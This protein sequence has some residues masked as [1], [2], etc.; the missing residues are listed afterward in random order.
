MP[1]EDYIRGVVVEVSQALRP[2]TD[3]AGSSAGVVDLMAELGWSVDADAADTLITAFNNVVTA[4]TTL[5]DDVNADADLS[6]LVGDVGAVVAAIVGAAPA[7]MNGL[8][9][10]F[11]QPKFWETL[12]GDLLECLVFDYL[13]RRY[14]LVL[15]V[16]AIVGVARREVREADATTGRIAYRRKTIALDEFGDFIS[17]PGD[18]LKERFGWGG[19]LDHEATLWTLHLIARGVG[20]ASEIDALEPAFITG[21]YDPLSEH[22]GDVQRLV[23]SG[24][25]FATPDG[26]AVAKIAFVV[27]PIPPEGAL[28]AAPEGLALL[29]VFMGRVSQTFDLGAVA[30]LTIAGGATV[31]PIEL[32]IRPSGV[33]ARLPPAGPTAELSARLDLAP[34]RP[35]V[36]VGAA[37][38]SRLELRKAHVMLGV[39]AATDGIGLTVE[40]SIDQ[41]ALV[42]QAGEGDGFLSTVLGDDPIEVSLG[43]GILWSS[44]TGLTITGQKAIE[45]DIPLDVNIADI[46]RIVRLHLRAQPE[47]GGAFA[48]DVGISGNLT[49]GPVAAAV[50]DLGVRVR[51]R[52][53]DSAHP[54]NLGIVDLGFAFK[55]PTGLGITVD[56]GPVSGGGFISFE[57][58]IGR[59]SGILHLEIL[60]VSVTVIGLIETK[61]PDGRDGFS[62]LLIVC[63]E[64]SPI[65]LGYGFTLNGV[66]GLAGIH[67]AMNLEALRTGVYTGSLDHILFPQD[68]IANAPQLI[69]DLSR[70]FPVAENSYT[71]GPMAKLGWGAS[72]IT[73]SI[74]VVIQLPS[75]VRIALLGQILLALPQPEDAVVELHIDFV[76]SLD[77]DEKLLALD[78]TLRDS[79]IAVFTLTGDMA[80]RLCWGSQPNFTLAMGGFHPHFPTPPGFPVLRRLALSLGAG[81]YIQLNCQTYQ[82]V[83]SNTVQIGARLELSVE[84]GV[85]IHGWFGFDAMFIL[86]PFSFKA[87][88]CAGFSMSVSGVTLANATVEGSFSGP[89]PWRFTGDAK[90]SVL[91]FEISAHVDERFGDATPAT[92][93]VLDPWVDLIA[94]AS[95][96][97][98]WAG[99]LA[100]D[101]LPI[102]SLAAAK[103]D[104]S[105][106]VDPAGRITWLQHVA[107]L[108][109]R[110]TKYKNSPIAA[111]ITFTVDR[112]TVGGAAGKPPTIEDLF[113]AG[114]YE[115]LSDAQKLSRPSFERMN[116]GVEITHSTL[117]CGPGI[118]ATIEYE[119]RIIDT[120]LA[121]RRT[122][123]YVLPAYILVAQASGGTTARSALRNGG[124]RKFESDRKFSESGELY[125]VATTDDLT[126]RAD[127]QAGTSQGAAHQSLEIYLE[128][129]PEER[130]RLQVVP[131]SELEAA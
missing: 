128:Q 58:E 65:Q 16:L 67:R 50:Q 113:P 15:G 93:D 42:V 94:A 66:G 82:A 106:L 102:V 13:D 9:A 112:V 46:I 86:T 37:D 8:P 124:T 29:P 91:F 98:N 19:A 109:R 129:H 72:I 2:L 40:S 56:A 103:G 96:A 127:V 18:V 122:V 25:T 121:S 36:L 73:V 116:G 61:L 104:L 31:A 76:A 123:S 78:A 126:L 55:P 41:M 1:A 28:D 117:K 130:G 70:I 27:L 89:R 131:L 22:V 38:S 118:P 12:P 49:I 95:D 69:S 110:I 57:P 64:F 120:E 54:G 119:T 45:L 101:V 53:T 7:V 17:T 52:S 68:P 84:V 80:M 24:P 83:T 43:I 115:D 88:F 59:Y 75:P 77:F 60:A 20:A 79:R 108:D 23:I 125:A 90:I 74:G 81:D 63:V 51:A 97:R 11:D 21:Y 32:D 34:A 87:E 3:S 107:P 47:S 33:S 10:P 85:S 4:L 39:Q 6:T 71:F 105:V 114:E 99:T 44:R 48:I 100:A 5:E 111:P 14:P 35:L 92:L 26:A 62:M 30:K